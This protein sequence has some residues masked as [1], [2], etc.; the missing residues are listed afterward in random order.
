MNA[1]GDAQLQIQG[2]MLDVQ[3]QQLQVLQSINA[4]LAGT[5]S[6]QH[7]GFV[8]FTTFAT[9]HAGERVVPQY[10]QSGG[11]NTYN[12]YLGSGNAVTA[13]DVI[14]EIEKRGGR[15][16]EGSILVKH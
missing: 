9:L 10:E 14:R 7:G 11:G 13:R 12:I 15:L 16:Q 1:Q 2:S 3:Q 6:R 8:P 5:E 4:A